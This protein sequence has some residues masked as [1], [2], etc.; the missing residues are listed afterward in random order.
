MF[1][2]YTFADV[3]P[4]SWLVV[5]GN[6]ALFFGITGNFNVSGVL[7]DW[8]RDNGGSPAS[9]QFNWNKNYV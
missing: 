3:Q 7:L 4:I 9:L 5:L 8:G 1:S 6:P 2:I